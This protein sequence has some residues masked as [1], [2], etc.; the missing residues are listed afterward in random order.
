[1][2]QREDTPLATR[3]AED[4][5]RWLQEVDRSGQQPRKR[6]CRKARKKKTECKTEDKEGFSFS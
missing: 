3:L 2:S 5:K 4:L 6:G 1:M